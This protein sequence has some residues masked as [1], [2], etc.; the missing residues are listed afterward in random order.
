MSDDLTLEERF[1]ALPHYAQEKILNDHRLWNVGGIDWWDNVFE[2]FV[3]DMK[4]DNIEVATEWCKSNKHS[5]QVHCI[6]FSGFWGQGDGALF[7]G[8]IIDLDKELMSYPVLYENRKD[9]D[10]RFWWSTYKGHTSMQIHDE[11]QIY[12]P[13]ADAG[14]R[15]QAQKQLV[16]E[17]ETAWDELSRAIEERVKSHSDDLYK[18]LEEEYEYLT[19]DEAVL[20]SLIA[21]E[22]LETLIK[23]HEDE[24]EST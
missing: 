22:Q 16:N 24:F 10:A 5:Y 3:E 13:S 11:I 4:D 6:Y 12:L 21:N 18:T 17:M 14:L 8:S 9:F 15:L 7:E 23:E 19:S 2:M 1:Q 20:E